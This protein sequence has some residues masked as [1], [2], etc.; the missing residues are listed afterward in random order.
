MNNNLI[1]IVQ[2][3]DW[4]LGLSLI[5][6]HKDSIAMT[7]SGKFSKFVNKSLRKQLI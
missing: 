7:N 2:I 1:D 4:W 3:G 5:T 6:Q